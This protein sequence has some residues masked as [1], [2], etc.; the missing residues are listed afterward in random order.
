[1][2][3]SVSNVRLE[4]CLLAHG[5]G[6]S[7]QIEFEFVKLMLDFGVFR[8]KLVMFLRDHR[9]QRGRVNLSQEIILVRDV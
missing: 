7:S 3:P 2:S 9:V 5:I 6:N 1:M 8:C 4:C